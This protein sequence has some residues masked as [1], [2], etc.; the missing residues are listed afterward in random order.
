MSYIEQGLKTHSFIKKHNYICLHMCERID[1][2]DKETHKSVNSA[3][4]G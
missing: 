4:R 3:S 2:I 1:K